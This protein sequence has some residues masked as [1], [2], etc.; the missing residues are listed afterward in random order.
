MTPP[1]DDTEKLL[2]ILAD[3][4]ALL[5]DFDGPICSVFAGIPA[6]VVAGQ[7]REILAEG[8]YPH[9]PV[10]VRAATDPFEVLFYAAK[11]GQ[12]EARYVEAA[13]RAHEVE[14]VH[15][16]RPTPSSSDLIR[17]WKATGR[18]L[19]VVSNNSAAAV[20]TYLNLHDL[21]AMVDLISARTSADVALLKPSP[22]LVTD[23]TTRLAILPSQC[24]LVGDSRTDIQAARAATVA[25]IGYANK[26]GKASSLAACGPDAI[27]TS[28]AMNV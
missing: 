24:V 17:A 4:K 20:E 13:F 12:D 22:F 5:L 6:P 1:I 8:G 26:P 15:S 28:M 18:P 19:A 11:L 21:R 10:D 27:T 3:S 14:A 25:A 23:A 9:L 2:S 16:A 7:L